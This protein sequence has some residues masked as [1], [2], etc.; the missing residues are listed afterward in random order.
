MTYIMKLANHKIKHICIILYLF[1]PNDHLI[2]VVLAACHFA[3]KIAFYF[4]RDVIKADENIE[5][6]ECNC[7][8][9]YPY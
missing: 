4:I 3:F 9:I 6:N 2:L 1:H 7:Q 8:I 5:D